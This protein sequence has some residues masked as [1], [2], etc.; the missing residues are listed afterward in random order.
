[1]SILDKKMLLSDL[2]RKLNAYVPAD[3]VRQIITDAG[4]VMSNYDVTAYRPD[5]GGDHDESIQ[6]IKMFLDAKEIEGKSPNT[7]ARYDYILNRLYEAVQVPLAKVTVYHIRQY[8][9]AEKAR[10]ICMNTIKGNCSVYSTFYAW[11]H[12]E[13]LITSDPTSNLGTV[14]ATVE[15]ELPFSSEEIQLIKESCVNDAERAVVHFLLTTG[16]RVSEVCSVNRSDIDFKNLRLFVTGKGNKKRTVYIDDVTALMLRRYLANR[17]DLE[18][19]LFSSTKGRYT[20]NGIQQM[21]RRIENRSHV[22]NVHPHR[23]RHTLA[24][25]LIDRGMSIQEVSAIL[26]HS[27]LDTTMI[28]VSVNERNTENSYRKYACL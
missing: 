26:G 27:K 8:M 22:P 15:K 19:A 14:K 24:T 10:G 3:T 9:M 28:Y 18:P 7:I 5:G 13:G 17:K 12:R 2:E 21:L 20:A 11:L 23:F 6:L 1:M 25:N 4:E 16:C